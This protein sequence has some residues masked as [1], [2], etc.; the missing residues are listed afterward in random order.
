M[1]W[2]TNVSPASRG[3]ILLVVGI[4]IFG[5]SDNLTLLVSDEVGVGQF[6]FSRSLI[7]VFMV[8]LLGRVFGLSVVPTQWKPVLARTFFMVF[9]IF[10]YFSVMPM[11]PIAEAGA[12][13]F[14]SPIFV[15]LFSVVVYKERIGWRRIFAVIVGSTGVL[16]VLQPG[17]EGFSFF[18]MLPVLSGASY[19]VGSIITFRLLQNESSFAILMSFIVSIGLCGAAVASGLTIFPASLDLLKQAPFL[20]RGWQNVDGQFWIWMAIIAASAS[21]ALSMMTRA[22]QLIKTSYAA[23][24][25]YAYIISVGFFSW[26]FWGEV[27]GMLSAIGILLIIMSG[28]IIVVAQQKMK[29]LP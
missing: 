7:A 5:F 2:L 21:L 22:Y 19:A 10:L 28:I 25:E 1:T 14:S 23:I 4:S 3:S 18:H 29:E 11:M 13:L 20:F 16:L 27:P 17:R 24:Y 12:G 26:F 6:H 9:A 15:L 8:V